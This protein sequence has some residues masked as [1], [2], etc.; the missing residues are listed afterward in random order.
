MNHS[1]TDRN[2]YFVCSKLEI[3]EFVDHLNSFDVVEAK[4]ELVIA[5]TDMYN[6]WPQ[7]VHKSR[8]HMYV[9]LQC[10]DDIWSL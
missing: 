9:M 1:L 4:Q 5:Y 3:Q 7:I 6:C 2:K 8:Q 10:T